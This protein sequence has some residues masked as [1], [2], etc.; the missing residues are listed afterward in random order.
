MFGVVISQI[1][2]AWGPKDTEL[3]LFS[4]IFEPIETH[5]DCSGS[6]LF[7]SAVEDAIRSA[8]VGAECSGGLGMAKFF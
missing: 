5:V 4:S 3:A 1:C 2:D 7:D 6:T 8:V